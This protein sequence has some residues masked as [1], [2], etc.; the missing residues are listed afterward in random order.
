MFR[1]KWSKSLLDCHLYSNI[2]RELCLKFEVVPTAQIR[3]EDLYGDALKWTEITSYLSEWLSIP[4]HGRFN[5]WY[6]IGIWQRT[7]SSDTKSVNW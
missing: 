5:L 6:Y 3:Y 4:D 1:T 2:Y 7:C